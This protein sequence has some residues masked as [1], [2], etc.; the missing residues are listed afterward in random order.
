MWIDQMP[1]QARLLLLASLVLSGCSTHLETPFYSPDYLPGA[2]DDSALANL[3]KACLGLAV[4]GT[5]QILPQGCANNLN[6]Q[7]MVE[8]ASDLH[9]GQDI[10]PTLSAPVARAAER[11]IQG[12]EARPL[13]SSSNRE[14]SADELHIAQ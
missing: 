1:R 9:R 13:S 2:G 6:L 10:G 8:S 11:Y 4:Q 3:P 14:A 7:R 5:E 12:D